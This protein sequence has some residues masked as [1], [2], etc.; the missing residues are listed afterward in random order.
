MEAQNFEFHFFLGGGG[1]C[2]KKNVWGYPEITNNLGTLRGVISINF[3]GFFLEEQTDKQL[4]FA[5]H[6]LW[7]FG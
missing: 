3:R 5:A 6:N 7:Q 4:D 1:G 2:Q